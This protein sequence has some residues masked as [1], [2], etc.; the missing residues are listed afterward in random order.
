MQR[1]LARMALLA[2]APA[3]PAEI[4]VPPTS[5]ASAAT[6]RLSIALHARAQARTLHFVYA[7][8]MHAATACLPIVGCA[9]QLNQTGCAG[10]ARFR[11]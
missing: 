9:G 8:M 5:T 10:R 2:R 11:L 7:R 1:A 4:P 3:A 6:F